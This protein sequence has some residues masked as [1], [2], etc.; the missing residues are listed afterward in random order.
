[1]LQRMDNIKKLPT[2]GTQDDDT[3]IKWKHSTIP[4]CVGHH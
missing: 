2:L 1:M 4:V 3:Q